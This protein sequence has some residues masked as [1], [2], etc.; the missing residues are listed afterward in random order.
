MCVISLLGSLG[1]PCVQFSLWAAR[2][3]VYNSVGQAIEGRPNTAPCPAGLEE[4]R[5]GMGGN[6]TVMDGQYS[7]YRRAAQ[8]WA[9]DNSSCC[10]CIILNFTNWPSSLKSHMAGRVGA[11]VDSCRLPGTGNLYRIAHTL[12]LIYTSK[13]ACTLW[14]TVSE[15][16]GMITLPRLNLWSSHKEPPPPLPLPLPLTSLPGIMQTLCFRQYFIRDPP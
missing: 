5:P 2:I 6:C 9:S 14:N 12:C 10:C 8:L 7:L 1:S 3:L 11:L 4:S 15:T 16:E 13:T